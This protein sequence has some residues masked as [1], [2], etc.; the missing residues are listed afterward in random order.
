V[1]VTPKFRLEI[2]KL[3]AAGTRVY[4]IAEATNVRPNEL[5]GIATGSIVV[6]P[7]DPRVLRVA[8]YL[9][10]D[11]AECFADAAEAS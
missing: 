11:P 5:S 2:L 9:G 3:R 6:R 7:N 4:Q 1:R 10:L 8:E